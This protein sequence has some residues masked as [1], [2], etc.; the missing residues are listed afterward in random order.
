MQEVALMT[1]PEIRKPQE[2]PDT[3]AEEGVH[4]VM[5]DPDGIRALLAKIK[6]AEA[7]E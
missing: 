7:Q 3:H 6:N 5:L 2:T 4:G 1:S